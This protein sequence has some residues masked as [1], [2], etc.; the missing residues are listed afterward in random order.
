MP[1]PT[2]KREQRDASIEKILAAAL[3]LFV[4]QGY[5][6]TTVEQVAEAAGLTKGSV[7]FYFGN[8]EALLLALLDRVEEVVVDHTE[9]LVDEAAP[10]PVQ[11]LVTFIHGQAILGV[12]RWQQVLLLVLMSLEFTGTDSTIHRR[13]EQIYGRLQ[14]LVEGIIEFGK[15]HGRFRTDLATREQAAVVI[16]GHDG[17]FLEWYRRGRQLDGEELVRALREATLAGLAARRPAGSRAI[18]KPRETG[19]T[20]P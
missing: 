17:T 2:T 19:I 1:R 20:E 8:K 13:T 3:G 11:R 14:R 4:S 18:D 12:D 5:R 9:R 15:T 16:A 6:Q 10:D 7:Y